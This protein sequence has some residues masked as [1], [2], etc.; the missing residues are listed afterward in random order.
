MFLYQNFCLRFGVMFSCFNEMLIL[1]YM[2]PER[3]WVCRFICVSQCNFSCGCPI[4]YYVFNIYV[5]SS[6]SIGL[7]PIKFSCIGLCVSLLVYILCVDQFA[8]LSHMYVYRYMWLLSVCFCLSIYVSFVC[9]IDDCISVLSS[10]CVYSVVVSMNCAGVSFVVYCIFLYLC[11]CCE[12]AS[13]CAGFLMS[14]NFDD[15]VL[16]VAVY[17]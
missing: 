6:L 13:V 17:H 5:P 2:W 12:D 11:M 1:V 4:V 15:H 16:C 8:S 14:V 7:L 10:L 3:W 9:L